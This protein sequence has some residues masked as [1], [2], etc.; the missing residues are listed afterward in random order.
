MT[1]AREDESML[2]AH[3]ATSAGLREFSAARALQRSH[4][5]IHEAL[6]ASEMSQRELAE[7]LEVTE[8]RVSQVLSGEADVLVTTVARY[9]AAT[10]YMLDLTAHPQVEGRPRIGRRRREGRGGRSSVF[11]NR[12]LHEGVEE[13]RLTILPEH[14]PV[15][16]PPLEET[17]YVGRINHEASRINFEFETRNHGELVMP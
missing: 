17:R 2:E 7:A 5:L 12:V 8:G 16:A 14:V 9:L 10:G 4:G 11:A 1:L 3:V 13:V 15:S 6:R